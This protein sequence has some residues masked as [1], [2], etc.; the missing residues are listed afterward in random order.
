M[1]DKSSKKTAQT[2]SS[3]AAK[4]GAGDK[5]VTIL[6]AGKIGFAMAVLLQ[7]AGGYQLRIADQSKAQLKAAAALGP[8]DRAYRQGW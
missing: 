7:A 6:G 3:S 1:S 4:A 2:S 5:K 8:G